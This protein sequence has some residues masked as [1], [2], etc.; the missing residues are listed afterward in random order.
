[1]T[2]QKAI[3][4]DPSTLPHRDRYKLLTGLV[5]PRPIAFVTSMSA[6]GVINAAP[7]SFFNLVADDPAVCV[8]GIDP[9]PSG[10][11]KDT[12]ANAFATGEFV[13][14]LVD[15][16]LGPKMNLCATDF[17]TGISEP[18]EVGLTLVP[19]ERVKVPRLAE[20]PV[21]L[22]CTLR[23][24]VELGK[25][26]YVLLGNVLH[27]HARAGLVDPTNLRT[28]LSVYRPLARLSG[29]QYASLGPLV[30][31]ERLN[32]AQWQE[33]KEELKKKS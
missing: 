33:R 27:L 5:I 16:A 4:V 20:A 26:H 32:Y 22:E 29:N 13:V 14:N 19:S 25:D 11:P 3:S 30:V 18:E 2:E 31:H 23:D 1:M 21:S 17:P 28:D 10:G 6:E 9:K 7:F 15:E 8:I 12:V 24:R